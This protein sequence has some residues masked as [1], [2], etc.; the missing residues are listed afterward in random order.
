MIFYALYLTAAPLYLD[1]YTPSSKKWNENVFKKA[2][3]CLRFEKRRR[4]LD[5]TPMTKALHYKLFFLKALT[6]QLWKLT[7]K[8]K[9]LSRLKFFAQQFGYDIDEQFLSSL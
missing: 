9:Q 3:K 1:L 7:I 8:T 5:W 4:S 2:F 6:K